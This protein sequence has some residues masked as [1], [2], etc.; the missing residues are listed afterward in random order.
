MILQTIWGC[1]PELSKDCQDMTNLA[2]TYFSIVVGA[3]IGAAIS[4]WIYYRQKKTAELQDAVLKRIEELNERHDKILESIQQ[5]EQRHQ[6]TLEVIQ[7]IERRLN[8]GTERNDA[9]DS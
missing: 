8:E 3:I 5:V 6:D 9:T 7:T 1:V 2:S 4:W